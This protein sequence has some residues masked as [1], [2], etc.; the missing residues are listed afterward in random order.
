VIGKSEDSL[1]WAIRLNPE[2]VGIGYGWVIAQYTSAKNVETVQTIASP[3]HQLISARTSSCALG[4]A[5]VAA[6]CVAARHH[7]QF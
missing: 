3:R 7:T 6:M 2:K 4:T 1:W 5:T